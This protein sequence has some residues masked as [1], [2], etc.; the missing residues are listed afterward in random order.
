MLRVFVLNAI[1][2]ESHI[3]PII[4]SVIMLNVVLLGVAAPFGSICYIFLKHS[5]CNI[6]T[7]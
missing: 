6:D 1:Y 2:V 3:N 5:V 7:F 4:L